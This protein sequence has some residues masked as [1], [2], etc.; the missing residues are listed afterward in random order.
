M[1]D[2]GGALAAF[3]GASLA[4]SGGVVHHPGEAQLATATDVTVGSPSGRVQGLGLRVTSQRLLLDSGPRGML[5]LAVARLACVRYEERGFLFARGG[6][7]TLDLLPED[8]K[9]APESAVQLELHLH[10]GGRDV[11]SALTTA[12][13]SAKKAAEANAA[14]TA[15]E[16]TPALGSSVAGIG[17]IL[18]RREEARKADESLVA[19]GLRDL[20][21]LLDLAP[22]LAATAAKLAA[23]NKAKLADFSPV[24]GDLG[25]AAPVSRSTEDGGGDLYG[26]L[27]KEVADWALTAIPQTAGCMALADVY[28]RYNRAR[29]SDLVSPT[30]LL[31]ACE[32]MSSLHLPVTLVDI[33][34][35]NALFLATDGRP[36]V[37]T[38]ILDM[39]LQGVT[40]LAVS[41]ATG[42]GASLASAMLLRME[43]TGELCRDESP[44]GLRAFYVNIFTAGP[45]MLR[46][47]AAAQVR[48]AEDMPS[49]AAPVPG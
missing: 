29:G 40:Y 41:K 14:L 34:G 3:R 24:L 35:T 7:V 45:H 46:R 28:C 21:A 49:Q 31:R 12:L 19:E 15:V 25:I 8:D 26:A 43:A 27:A 18:V 37:E 4:P 23:R 13:A 33:A 32:R 38:R 39:A 11:A 2:D 48:R 10:R 1:A 16:V 17:G 5:E 30:D 44:L 22:R 47:M 36:A 42:V 20:Q 6:I 9:E